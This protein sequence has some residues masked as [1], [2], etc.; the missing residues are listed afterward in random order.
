MNAP[1]STFSTKLV[2]F[3]D[4]ANRAKTIKNEAR[5]NE[6]VDQK[7]LLRKHE[8]ELRRLREELEQ[9]SR[10]LVDKRRLLEVEEQKRRAEQ[11]KLAAITA[12]EAR[13][14]EFMKEK[15]DKL[16]LEERISAVILFY[17]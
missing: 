15:Q 4:F 11:D 5:V 8:R 6:D 1:C 16:K 12:L 14:R 13:S 9:R 2:A 3:G 7:T 17:R 10:D